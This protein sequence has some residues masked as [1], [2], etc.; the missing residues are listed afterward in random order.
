MTRDYKV[1]RNETVVPKHE[2]LILEKHL[3]VEIYVFVQLKRWR[4][5]IGFVVVTSPKILKLR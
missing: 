5:P 2:Q 1:Q 3:G 4:T